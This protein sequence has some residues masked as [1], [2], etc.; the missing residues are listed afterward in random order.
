MTKQAKCE[1]GTREAI[2]YIDDTTSQDYADREAER[3]NQQEWWEMFRTGA[4]LCAVIPAA[5]SYFRASRML[6]DIPF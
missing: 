5:E 4:E 1:R 6:E 3:D 2:Q